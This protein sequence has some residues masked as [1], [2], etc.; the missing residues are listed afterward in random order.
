[1]NT[2]ITHPFTGALYELTEDGNIRVTDGD[3]HGLFQGDGQWISGSIREAD[4][5]LC[6]WVTN[7]I[8]EGTEADSDS[9]LAAN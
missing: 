7:V 9:H 6:V 3:S 2:G 8:P 4:P 5:Q 1:M